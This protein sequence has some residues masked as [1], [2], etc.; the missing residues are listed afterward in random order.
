[1]SLA[2]DGVHLDEPRRSLLR[3]CISQTPISSH[4][5]FRLHFK[6]ARTRWMVGRSN[7]TFIK[8]SRIGSGKDWWVW[9][10]F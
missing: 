6:D 4:F 1:M 2:S 7:S 10:A 5:K 8:T 3:Q 9:I